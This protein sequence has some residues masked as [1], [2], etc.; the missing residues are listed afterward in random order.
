MISFYHGLIGGTSN[1][2]AVCNELRDT[3]V[4]VQNKEIGYNFLSLKKII[5]ESEKDLLISPKTE[6]KVIVGN[7]LGC[8]IA[9]GL[10]EPAD[11]LILV[12]PPY[13]TASGSLPRNP[14]SIR[15]YATSLFHNKNLNET[16]K[17]SI[18]EASA[19]LSFFMSN[20]D[21]LQI[22][23]EIKE[24]ILDFEM[25]IY[26]SKFQDK[27]HFILGE[28]D[29]ITPAVDFENFREKYAPKSRMTIIKK[30]GHAVPLERPDDVVKVIKEYI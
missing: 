30:C 4:S 19:K 17:E 11:K 2:K 29:Y 27:I 25:Q 23:R 28:D 22:L 3:G 6:K 21:N 14:E 12:A 24:A 10:A 13:E 9:L 7:S 16:Q 1:W 8:L 20:K 15:D 18:V 26:I 5:K